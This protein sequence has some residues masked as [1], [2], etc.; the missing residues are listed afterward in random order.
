MLVACGAIHT[1]KSADGLIGWA[2]ALTV[3]AGESSGARVATSAAMLGVIGE[4]DALASAVGVLG[5]GAN[6]ALLEAGLIG[7]TIGA[8]VGAIVAIGQAISSTEEV[9][10]RALASALDTNAGVTTSTTTSAAV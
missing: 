8:K 3:C 10:G 9:I 6:T 4:V 2:Y 1:L 7:A 5:I